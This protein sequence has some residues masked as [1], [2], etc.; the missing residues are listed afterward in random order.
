MVVLHQDGNVDPF[1]VRVWSIEPDLPTHISRWREICPPEKAPRETSVQ[2][3]P[4]VGTRVQD[5][6][7][8]EGCVDTC[9]YSPWFMRR[10]QHHRHYFLY[11]GVPG[12]ASLCTPHDARSQRRGSHGNVGAM[13][14]S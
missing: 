14:T 4:S 10:R 9:T 3:G 5:L 7:R 12:R 11:H 2:D 6:T 8:F 13:I 1:I